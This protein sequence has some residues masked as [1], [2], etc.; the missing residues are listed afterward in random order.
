MEVA[1]RTQQGRHGQSTSNTAVAVCVAVPAVFTVLLFAGTVAA[2]LAGLGAEAAVAGAD[3]GIQPLF[4]KACDLYE[5]GDFASAE[6]SLETIR[7]SGV[8][9]ATVYY[10][11][12]NCYYKQG[13]MGRA[14]VN[15]RRALI[16]APRDGDARANLDLIR[17]SVGGGDTTAA[18]GLAVASAL[19]VRLFSPK[20]LQFL[21]YVAY[22][23]GAAFFLG[24]LF[25]RERS[26]RISIYGFVL[27][28][29]VA[30]LA[31]GFSRYVEARFT[32]SAEA[33][34]VV[35]RAGL[36]SGPGPAFDEISTLPDGLELRQRARSGIWVEVQLPTGE[37]GWVRE[38]DIETI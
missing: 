26:R 29:V 37:V 2:L 12:G 31:F 13:Q 27:S 19:P 35:D 21:F 9:N 25:L 18:Y 8:R 17:S 24:T 4:G 14:V 30:G 1:G 16:L 6:A 23:F 34:V 36:K 28:V 20:Q 32:S 3:G 7:A 15:Y 5:S 11:L 38:K 10:N 33:V 22:Y